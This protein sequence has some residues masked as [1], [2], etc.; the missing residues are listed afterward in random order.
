M[1]D[2]D[3]RFEKFRDIVASFDDVR[4]ILGQPT[5]A[6]QAKVI[7]ELD[8][9]CRGIIAKAPFVLVASS[10]RAGEI[11]VSP[12]GDP[13]G[14]VQILDN[15]RLAIPERLGNR[16]ADTFRNVL[17]NPHVGLL[18]MIPGKSETLRIS[19]EARIVRDAALLETMAV[20]ERAPKVALVVYVERIMIHCPKCMLRSKL[21]RPEAWPDHSDTATIE[22]AMIQHAKLDVT[23][24]E[25]ERRAV[26]AGMRKLY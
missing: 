8:A 25:Y 9:V 24:E 15:K 21:W 19:G 20:N 2:T 4:E 13:A 17:D 10:N 23:P 18:F 7:D 6:V 11:D 16:R 5:E 14:F 12:K 1:T 3:E 22:E 26:A